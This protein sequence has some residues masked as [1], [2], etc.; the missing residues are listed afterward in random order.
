MTT[1]TVAAVATLMYFDQY[2]LVLNIG[3]YAQ[4]TGH[5]DAREDVD[6]VT[7]AANIVDCAYDADCVSKP[8]GTECELN[9]LTFRRYSRYCWP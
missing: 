5:E 2:W 4:L 7:D 8:L 6:E 1:T 9:E 3:K